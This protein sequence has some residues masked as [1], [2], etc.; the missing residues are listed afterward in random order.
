MKCESSKAS[1]LQ[2]DTFPMISRNKQKNIM[3]ALKLNFIQFTIKYGLIY[4][5][6][7]AIHMNDSWSKNHFVNKA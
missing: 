1:W 7:V 5:I 6:T 4:N 2:T 3:F